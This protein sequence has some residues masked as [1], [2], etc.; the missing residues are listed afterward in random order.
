MDRGNKSFFTL[1]SANLCQP[2]SEDD[3]TETACSRESVLPNAD[4]LFIY[5]EMLKQICRLNPPVQPV[6][7]PD[8]QPFDPMECKIFSDMSEN[9]FENLQKRNQ[10]KQLDQSAFT[11]TEKL[12]KMYPEFVKDN[13]ED[14]AYRNIV[15]LLELSSKKQPQQQQQQQ[16]ICSFVQQK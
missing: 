16:P 7:P 6:Q 2:S 8:L 10:R 1:P 12:I 4:K 9:H 14:D 5:A 11:S 3:L 13:K 15:Q